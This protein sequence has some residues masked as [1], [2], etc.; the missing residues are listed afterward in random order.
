[1]TRRL[2]LRLDAQLDLEEG[3]EWYQQKRDG[4]GKDFIARVG[5]VMEKLRQEPDLGIVVWRQ[6]RRANVKRFPYGG[7]LS[8]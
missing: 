3:L 4:L 5:E 6:L 8:R 1:V 7:F 2:V